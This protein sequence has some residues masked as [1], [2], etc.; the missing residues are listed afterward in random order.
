MRFIGNKERL[1]SRIYA[2]LE[3]R[4]IRGNSFFDFFSGTTNVAQFFKKLNYQIYSSDMLY[5]SY[6]LQK[7]YIENNAEPIFENL[8]SVLYLNHNKLFAE[9]LEKTLD[10]LN[11]VEPVEGFI[12]H[13]YSPGGTKNL[14]QPR[15]YF[16]DY[17][18]KKIDAIRLKIEE[19]NNNG[20]LTENEYFIL[21]SCLIESVFFFANVSGVFAAFQ[22]KWD[23]RAEKP[24]VLRKI[25]LIYNNKINK[26]FFKNSLALVP[27]VSADIVYVDPP[28]NERQYLPNYHI[29]ETIAKY[30]NP[31]IKGVS[32]MRDYKNQK[33]SFCNKETALEGLQYTAEN[34]EY[35]FLLLSYNSEGIMN[36]DDIFYIFKKY[37][38]VEM[39]EFD[40]LRFKSNNNGASKTKK[41]VKEQLYIVSRK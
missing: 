40:Y 37:G 31:P 8:F 10:Y 15:M 14:S 7:A 20:L 33:S 32:G 17:N 16:S 12:Y 29:I 6:C 35:N 21:L 26:S 19:W 23:P 38:N 22:K 24:F 4:N 34:A 13:N 30:D 41:S 28:Y 25:N 18:A 5:F 36:S 2:A 9:P 1:I 39:I 3:E 27:S 11:G